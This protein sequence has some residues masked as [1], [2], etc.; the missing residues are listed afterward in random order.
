MEASDRITDFDFCYKS[1]IRNWMSSVDQQSLQVCLEQH[2]RLQRHALFDN[3][4]VCY[5]RKQFREY[6]FLHEEHS[7]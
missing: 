2:Y 5:T 3:V 6:E 4:F 7:S 1:T